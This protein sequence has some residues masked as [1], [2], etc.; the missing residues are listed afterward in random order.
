MGL[1][2]LIVLLAVVSCS[3]AQTYNT[4]YDN[5]D[6][7]QILA[8][9]RLL[10]NYIQ[11]LLDENA[12]RCSPEGREFKKYIPEAI[13]TNCAKCSD[14]QKRIVKKTAKHIITNRPQDWE[15][16]KQKFDPQGKY[17]QSFNDFLNSR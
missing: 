2:R 15:K 6:I 7:D 11:C 3:F 9:K 4:R 8:S 10:D 12:K 16:I 5:I 13:R 17:H 14:S 1:T